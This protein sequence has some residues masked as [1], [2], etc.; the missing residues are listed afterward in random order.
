MLGFLPA[1][2]LVAAQQSSSSP[3]TFDL[4]ESYPP[5]TAAPE[6]P[7]TWAS[8]RE[9]GRSSFRVSRFLVTLG[10]KANLGMVVMQRVAIQA[11]NMFMLVWEG[12][13]AGAKDAAARLD[14]FQ[15]PEAWI[16]LPQLEVDIYRGLGAEADYQ[17]F[18]GS[19]M[20]HIEV[21]ALAADPN[22]LIT[23]S[24]KGS[25]QPEPGE[26]IH[27]QLPVGATEVTLADDQDGRRI[28]YS[29]PVGE[30]ADLGAA[31]GITRIG[32]ESF[33]ALDPLWLAIP[34]PALDMGNLQPPR[35]NLSV[36]HLAHL[37]VL[38]A[39]L[40]S[41][42]FQEEDKALVS[43]FQAVTPGVAWPYFL[44]GDFESHQ[45][46][47]RNWSLRLDSKAKLDEDA[48]R[49]LVRL[50]EVLEGWIPGGNPDWTVGSFPWL[51]DRVLPTLIVLDEQRGWFQEPVDAPLEGLARRVA[52]ARLLCQQRCGIRQHG[53]GSAAL[54]LEASL[55]E[56]LTYRLLQKSGNAEDAEAMLAHWKRQETLAG[57]LPQPLSTLEIDDLYG[58]KRLLSF[59]PLVW[60][61]I[62]QTCGQAAFDSMIGEVLAAPGWW[63]TRDLEQKLA[64]AAPE[65]DWDPFLVAHLYGRTLPAAR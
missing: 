64:K 36:T 10:A 13:E 5:F 35:W 48:V 65:F 6:S 53:Q 28:R 19:L 30:E 8:T 58:P 45:T 54:F 57:P 50:S 63:S 21:P 22:L 46:A 2:L 1:I 31:Y 14:A 7:G 11:D 4:P 9:D 40:V 32:E 16:S 47:G 49:E 3:F 15:V 23:M 17:P 59:G 33:S 55:A 41:K 52:L 60:L 29:L 43:E 26:R 61:A 18:P 62:E 39:P 25:H 51:G 24:Y 34:S 42:S 20:I 38:S 56:F 44:V 37:E 27:W 12:P